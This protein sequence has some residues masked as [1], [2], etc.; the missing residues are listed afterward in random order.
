[1]SAAAKWQ[2]SNRRQAQLLLL[3]KALQI[4]S[5]GSRVPTDSEPSNKR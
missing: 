2:R 4:R 3:S 1:M 5:S